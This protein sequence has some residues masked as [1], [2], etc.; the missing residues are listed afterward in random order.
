MLFTKGRTTFRRLFYS[1]QIFWT[2]RTL[3][4]AN[5]FSANSTALPPFVP[6]KAPQMKY[7]LRFPFLGRCVLSRSNCVRE[8][9][10]YQ[11]CFLFFFL[12]SEGER[13]N[14]KCMSEG[15]HMWRLRS[16]NRSWCM[17]SCRLKRG[18]SS[19]FQINIYYFFIY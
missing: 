18:H 19:T 13:W 1:Y 15:R 4:R 11:P 6:L 10:K 5:H 3:R 2:S 17:F 9:Q 14:S 8:F 7:H 12:S 16:S